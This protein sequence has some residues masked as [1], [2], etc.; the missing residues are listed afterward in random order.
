MGEVGVENTHSEQVSDGQIERW[1]ER[2]SRKRIREA[3]SD[4]KI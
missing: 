1:K 2:G 3:E 4:R